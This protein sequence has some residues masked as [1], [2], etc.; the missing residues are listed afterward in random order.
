MS[1]FE[2]LD[3][4]EFITCRICG[5]KKTRIYGHHLKTIHNIT[6]DEYK[7][8]FPGSPLMCEVDLKRTTINGG[9]HMKDEKYKKMF[10]EMISGEKNPNHN[11]K[12][13]EE[14]RKSRSPFSKLFVKYDGIEDIDDHISKFTKKALKNRLT[15]NQKEYYINKGFTEEEALKMVSDRQKTFSLEKCIQK[16]GEEKGPERWR[17]RQEKWLN[18][19]GGINYSDISQELFIS[20]YEKLKKYRFDRKVYFA[21]LDKNGEIHESN[22]NYE[23]RLNL[24]N[25]YILPDFFIPDLK[26]ILEFDGTYYHRNTTENKLRTEKRDMDIVESG[27]EVIHISEREYINNKEFTILKLL[28]IIISKSNSIKNDK[29]ND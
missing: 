21:R 8:M 29:S 23:Y 9:K 15:T 3:T 20:L 2:V 16:W 26:F 11:N 5:E 19:F 17:K 12:T 7:K 10:S 13:T 25:S 24:K 28:D 22:K 1:N 4:E 27:Y 14:E 18:S 6:S